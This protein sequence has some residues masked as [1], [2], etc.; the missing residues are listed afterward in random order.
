M[1]K[2]IFT[3]Q[4]VADRFGVCKNTVIY[5]LN[6]G[7]IK[8]PKRDVYFNGR[9]WTEEDLKEIARTMEGY[10]LKKRGV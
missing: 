6:T 8:E 2:K 5:W 4:Q 9:L 10:K 7:K 1:T 3:T